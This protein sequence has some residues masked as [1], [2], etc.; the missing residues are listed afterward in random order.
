MIT[1]DILI[2]GSGI[3]GLS[4]ARELVERRPDLK[5]LMLEKEASLAVHASGRNSGV[6]HA[7]FYYEPDSL[8]ARLTRDGN[9]LLTEYCLSNDLAINRCG[10]VVVARDK[11]ELEMLYE[12]KRRGES[13]GVALEI[14]DEE[15][16]RDLEPAAKTFRKALYSPSTSTIDPVEVVS[17]IGDLLRS[18]NVEI[19]FNE[20]FTGFEDGS[21]IRTKKNRI[22]FRHLVN[23]G[24][25]Y[26]DKIAHK[27]GVGQDYII[28]PFKGLYMEYMDPSLINRLIYPVPDLKNP[29]LGVHFTRSVHGKI[30]IGPTAVP[31]LW[32]ENYGGLS[33]FDLRELIENL[34]TE[35][36][37]FLSNSF[38][39][40][41]L[42]MKEMKKY[43]RATLIEQAS[44]LVKNIEPSKAGK[45]LAPGIRAQLLDKK[46]KKLV[47]DFVVKH[48]RNSTH[49]LN[50]VSPAFTCAFSF[51]SFI[52]DDMEGRGAL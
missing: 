50:A 49:V 33:N 38:N 34:S 1:T 16:L 47:M 15:R 2:I 4:I 7:G 42:A 31:A 43:N 44:H 51:S 23:A 25:L 30:K 20:E 36:S 24:G 10:K 17:H 40:R 39:F 32:R 48:G 3:I 9:R 27:A 28:I 19:M 52:V 8:K 13:N 14:V 37:L 22:E 18:K 46:E 5:V 45:Y 29:F 21:T 6:V 35:A 12:L 11:N 26:A 41:E